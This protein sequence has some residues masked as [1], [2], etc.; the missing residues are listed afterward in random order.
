MRNA[1]TVEYKRSNTTGACYVVCK[2]GEVR[3]RFAYDFGLD[4]RV[5]ELTYAERFAKEI[6]RA[7]GVEWFGGRI[8][9]DLFAFVAMEK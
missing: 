7:E 1:I 2:C 5:A 3:K 6:G 8:K 4:E 9:E